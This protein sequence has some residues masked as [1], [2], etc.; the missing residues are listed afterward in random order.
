[1]R[2][3]AAV[4]IDELVIEFILHLLEVALFFIFP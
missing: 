1:M 4:S 3:P 2:N